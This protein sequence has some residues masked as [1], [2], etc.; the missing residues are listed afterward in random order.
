ME[1]IGPV[2]WLIIIGAFFYFMMKMG[3]CCGGGHGHGGS[4]RDAVSAHRHDE[5][6]GQA[7]PKEPGAR[8][9]EHAENEHK[10]RGGC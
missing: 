5:E 10:R 2:I 1:S 8:E 4:G 3:G 9:P 6:S 7:R